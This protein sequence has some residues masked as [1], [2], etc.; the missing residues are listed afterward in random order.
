MAAT[1]TT[2]TKTT[3]ARK[4]PMRRMNERRIRWRASALSGGNGSPSGHQGGRWPRRPIGSMVPIGGPP[5][6]RH[7]A[8]RYPTPYTVSEVARRARIRLELAADVLDVGVDRALVRLEGDA[9]DLVQQLRA[10][11]DPPGLAGHGRQ[12]RELGGGQ[13]H[14][15]VA[16]GDAHARHVQAQVPSPK[17]LALSRTGMPAQDRAHAGHQLARAERLRDVVVRAELE[18]DDPVGLVVASGEHDDRQLTGTTDGARHVQPVESR[19]P[20]IQHHEVRRLGPDPHQRLVAGAGR[21]DAEARIGQVVGD[22]PNDLRLVVHDQDGRHGSANR[23][24]RA[25]RRRP[26]AASPARY[27]ADAARGAAPRSAR[28]GRPS[29]QDRPGHAGR[30]IGPSRTPLA[31][32][33]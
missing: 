11:E 24:R 19:Q 3:N 27:R 4:Q 1:R 18:A 28:I 30:S 23:T 5:R 6:G 20:E 10:R 12:E 8:R 13:L 33:R 14:R 32:G 17:E 2:R 29:H 25:V 16:S 9:V 31:P 26:M 22:E 21:R 7:S 15:L